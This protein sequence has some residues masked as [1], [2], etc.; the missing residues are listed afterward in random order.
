MRKYIFSKFSLT[1]GYKKELT[2]FVKNMCNAEIGGNKFY[3]GTGTH[4]M[5]N[6][7]EIVDLVFALKKYEKKRKKNSQVF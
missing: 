5:Q 2:E 3:D 6:P 1:N 7:K 4:Y